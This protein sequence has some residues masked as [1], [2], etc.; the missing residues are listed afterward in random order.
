MPLL[1]SADLETAAEIHLSSDS[2]GD[3]A[4]CDAT[5]GPQMIGVGRAVRGSGGWCWCSCR[6][7]NVLT[8]VLADEPAVCRNVHT[9]I[10]V[11]STITF[12]NR[13]QNMKNN[14]DQYWTSHIS[15]HAFERSVQPQVLLPAG[16]AGVRS[17]VRVCA[18]VRLGAL[19]GTP[20]PAPARD[21]FT[22]PCRPH[23][24]EFPVV[25]SRVLSVA[26]HGV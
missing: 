16:Q 13:F 11:K 26:R 21:C 6:G 20:L 22:T 14:R 24:G 25:L 9:R 5:A 18:R 23:P 10:C 7:A 19:Q 2:G 15:E 17:H 1:D 4:S 3:E 8:S 12:K